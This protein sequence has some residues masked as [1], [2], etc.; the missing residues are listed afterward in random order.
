M[1]PVCQIPIFRIHGKILSK[2]LLGKV[3]SR[4]MAADSSFA[5]FTPKTQLMTWWT[6]HDGRGTPSLD[7]FITVATVMPVILPIAFKSCDRCKTEGVNHRTA[8]LN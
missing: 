3:S 2:F 4:C 5:T 8:V 7:V 6:G 1:Y